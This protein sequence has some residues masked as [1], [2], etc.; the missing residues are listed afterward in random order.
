MIPFQNNIYQA[1]A[2]FTCASLD[3]SGINDCL[4]LYTNM[5]LLRNSLFVLQSLLLLKLCELLLLADDGFHQKHKLHIPFCCSFPG[6]VS[7][8]GVQ[9][10]LWAVEGG[11]KLVCSGLLKLAKANLIHSQVTTISLQSSG[12]HLNS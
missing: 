11:N 3:Q 9:T 1:K 2:K 6:A 8:A 10:N 7:L 5:L 12:I 4:Y